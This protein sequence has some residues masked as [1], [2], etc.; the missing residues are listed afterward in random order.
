MAEQGATTICELWNGNTANPQMS[1]QNHV[2]LLGDLMIWLYEDLAGTF[3]ERSFHNDLFK[4]N[5]F[6]SRADRLNE[7]NASYQSLY[8]TISS[9]WKKETMI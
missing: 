9:H 4:S 5:S 3:R 1:S 2:M 7:V 8:G 6:I